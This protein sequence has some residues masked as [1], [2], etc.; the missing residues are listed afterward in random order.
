MKKLSHKK[1]FTLLELLI[2]SGL[3][4][5]IV[6]SALSVYL[7]QHKHL[8]AQNQVTDM[9]AN[10]RASLQE[11]ATKIRMAGY[12][13]PNVIS[14]LNASNTNP[15][16]LEIVYDTGLLE[17][18][19]L[20]VAMADPTA[21]LRCD[22]HDDDLSPVQEGEWLFIYDP[23]ANV[24][25]FFEVSRII[26]GPARIQHSTMP[27]SRA[28]PESCSVFKFSR[29]K[30]YVDNTSDST[31]SNLMVSELGGAPQVYADN[32]T[33][34]QFSYVLSSGTVVDIPPLAQMVRMVVITLDAVTDRP[35]SEY[36]ETFRNR[37]RRLETTVKVRNLG[38][39]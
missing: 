9:Q 3:S 23:N 12:N 10:A 34:I 37:E 2:A 15:D 30:Y 7:A 11:L 6:S 22:N 29:T 20:R 4:V 31:H 25:E 1:G 13:V 33:D 14:A 28:Y 21:E 27:L 8:V 39:N 5:I 32:I 38:L 24:G 35:S 36:A 19:K 26:Y 16:T 18:V 17:G